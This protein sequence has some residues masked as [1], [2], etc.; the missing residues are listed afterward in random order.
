MRRTASALLVLLT[1]SCA[2]LVVYEQQVMDTL[3]FGTQKPDGGGVVSETDWQRFLANEITPRFPSG[4]TTWDA[5]GQ[6]RD[7]HNVIEREK[8]HIVQVVHFA[9]PGDEGR[10]AEIIDAYKKHFAQESVLRVRTD[11]WMIPEETKPI[12]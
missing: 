5:Y 6:W 7:S 2:N 4:F 1:L 8:T 11:V 3:Y 10:I 12:R 9:N